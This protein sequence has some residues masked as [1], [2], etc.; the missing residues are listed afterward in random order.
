[1]S[2]RGCLRRSRNVSI[3]TAKNP[4]P[5]DNPA[6][7]SGETR[8]LCVPASRRVCL[9]RGNHIIYHP[10]RFY[11]HHMG[12]LREISPTISDGRGCRDF[13]EP[14][15]SEVSRRRLRRRWPALPR[16]YAANY[17]PSRAGSIAPGV[18]RL[19]P[20]LFLLPLFTRVRGSTILRSPHPGSRI[21]LPVE[22]SWVV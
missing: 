18:I 3:G 9:C 12:H 1:M 7:S 20:R 19:Y 10:S 11:L 22:A 8:G 14:T 5:F 6:I 13:R 4:S 15:T 17:A 21:D 16:P 2:A